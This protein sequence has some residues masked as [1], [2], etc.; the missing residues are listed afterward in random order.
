MVKNSSDS[1]WLKSVV[2]YI[3][4]ELHKK[5]QTIKF[6]DPDIATLYVTKND[7]LQSKKNLLLKL[8][9]LFIQTSG[10]ISTM[11]KVPGL[12][13]LTLHT[14]GSRRKSKRKKSKSKRK[15]KSK[16]KSTKIN[17]KSTKSKRKSTKSKR[18]ITKSKRKRK[19]TPKEGGGETYSLV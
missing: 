7:F 2:P 16:R 12:P 14:G 13:K 1:E 11:E 8:N 10:E 15:T 6:T 9:N 18:N 3:L 19:K 4:N 17:R 5:V